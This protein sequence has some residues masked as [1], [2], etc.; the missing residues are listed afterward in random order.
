M[1]PGTG[2]VVRKMKRSHLGPFS[3]KEEAARAASKLKAAGVS[4]AVLP[5]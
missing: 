2:S 5:L 4:A 3:T 1:P